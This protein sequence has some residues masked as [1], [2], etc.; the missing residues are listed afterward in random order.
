MVADRQ[1]TCP[2][3]VGRRLTFPLVAG[4]RV[5]FPVV[6]ADLPPGGS[7]QVTF[8]LVAVRGPLWQV[9]VVPVGGWSA[10]WWQHGG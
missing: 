6:Q 1:V 8:P 5:T 10:L 9:P 2:M 4:R 7:L 3:V